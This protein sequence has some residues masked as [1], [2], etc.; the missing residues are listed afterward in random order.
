MLSY[1]QKSY[2]QDIIAGQQNVLRS[3]FTKLNDEVPT[4]S[5]TG[6]YLLLRRNLLL[7]MV[8]AYFLTLSRYRNM[9]PPNNFSI[10]YNFFQQ[11]NL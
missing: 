11:I 2:L 5:G 1:L 7:H 3:L 9:L 6:I 10:Y 4:T 8:K